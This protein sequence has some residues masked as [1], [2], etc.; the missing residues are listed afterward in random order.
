MADSNILRIGFLSTPSARRATGKAAGLQLR[1]QI[2][3]HA[4]REEGDWTLAT[5]PPRSS[6][7]YPRPPRGGRPPGCWEVQSDETFLSTP[8][9]RRATSNTPVSLPP[10]QHFYPRPPRGGRLGIEWYK[11]G[12]ILFL[13]TPSARR[14]TAHPALSRHERQIS[15]HAL[16]EEGDDV[17]GGYNVSTGAISIHALREEGDPHHVVYVQLLT[18]YF[19]PRP[20]R[21]GRR[22]TP[23]ALPGK[24][25]F[26]STPSARRATR[27][28]RGIQADFGI[29]IHALRE[30]GDLAEYAFAKHLPEISIHALREEGDLGMRVV[31]RGR[32]KFLSTPSA[33]RATSS[34]QR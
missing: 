17:V 32:A 12:G 4:L 6:N 16:R 27:H 21:G 9:A 1:F 14:A 11:E 20:P 26:L 22:P 3:I 13:S 23:R 33:R 18:G 15:I 24:V 19:Y 5:Q 10:V 7:F 31:F 2:S 34:R 25:E 8:S 30:E 29:S 28:Q